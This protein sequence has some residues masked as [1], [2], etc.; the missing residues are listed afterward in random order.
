MADQEKVLLASAAFVILILVKKK[1]PENEFGK[2]VY[3]S[4]K[5]TYK[6]PM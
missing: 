1:T 4:H 3:M 2:Q 6:Y 5:T